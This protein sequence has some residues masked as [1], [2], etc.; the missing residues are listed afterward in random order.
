MHISDITCDID[1][2]WINYVDVTQSNPENLARVNTMRT[3]TAWKEYQQEDKNLNE[4][5]ELLKYGVKLVPK[6]FQ[7]GL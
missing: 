2:G 3:A 7:K 1:V 6:D 5:K 4:V